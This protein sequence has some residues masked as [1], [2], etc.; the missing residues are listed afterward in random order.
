MKNI[1]QIIFL[2]AFYVQALACDV[3]NMYDYSGRQNQSY[4]GV[5]Y[6]YR[7]M[8]GYSDHL[9]N[10]HKFFIGN[11]NARVDHDL[12]GKNFYHEKTNMDFQKYH[13]VD[14]RFNYSIHKKINVGAIVPVLFNTSYYSAIYYDAVPKTDSSIYT[15]GLGDVFLFSDY[16]MTWSKNKNKVFFKPGI[17]LKLP[18]GNAKVSDN[19][20]LYPHEM[21]MGTGT[22]DLIL[23]LN[24][25]VRH[26]KIGTE[27]MGNYRINTKNRTEGYKFGNSLN[28]SLNPYYMISINDRISIIP[29]LGSYLEIAPKDKINNATLEGTGGHTWYGNVGFDLTVDKFVFQGLFQKPIRDRLNGSQLGNSGRII[30][31]AVYNL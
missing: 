24:A 22:T 28:L 16:V 18:T 7:V 6:R 5:F 26:K 1:H 17:A 25:N 10:T 23:R 21:Q 19:G 27:L 3:C 29:K 14:L 13:I 4:L 2:A 20:G 9:P 12:S 30:L 31:G 8:N 15:K 11:N